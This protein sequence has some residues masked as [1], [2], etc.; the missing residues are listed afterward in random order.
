MLLQSSFAD[1]CWL[2]GTP[3]KSMMGLLAAETTLRSADRAAN[4]M[5]AKLGNMRAVHVA[6]ANVYEF[7]S[8]FLERSGL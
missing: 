5:R 1:G 7:F 8:S 2:A 4:P 6:L 3:G